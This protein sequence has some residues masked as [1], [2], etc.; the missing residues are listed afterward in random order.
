[1]LEYINQSLPAQSEKQNIG[2]S[3]VRKKRV[4]G[5]AEQR[6]F[7]WFTLFTTYSRLSSLVS[8]EWQQINQLTTHQLTRPTPPWQMSQNLDFAF[9]FM[10]INPGRRTLARPP[11]ST[12]TFPY[13]FQHSHII[14][15]ISN[16]DRFL[17]SIHCNASFPG[18]LISENYS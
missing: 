5:K 9:P 6:E 4:V 16:D 2:K 15:L 14:T 7:G 18:K 11:Q 8:S 1:M 3:I 17:P 10:W 12:P 13:K